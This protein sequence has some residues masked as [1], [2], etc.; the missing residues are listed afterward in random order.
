VSLVLEQRS[1]WETFCFGKERPAAVHYYTS[2]R[3][4]LDCFLALERIPIAHATP[5]QPANVQADG[6]GVPR[7][8][9]QSRTGEAEAA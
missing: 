7:D 9:S 3:D 4:L 6:Q 5:T 1:A 8:G 2:V